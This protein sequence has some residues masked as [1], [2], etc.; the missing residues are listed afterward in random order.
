M[1][2]ANNVVISFQEEKSIKEEYAQLEKYP[3][4]MD[5]F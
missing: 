5:I 4:A 3:I 1:A 2:N